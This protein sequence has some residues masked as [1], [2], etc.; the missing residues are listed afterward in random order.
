VRPRMGVA[1]QRRAE[2]DVIGDVG[3]CGKGASNSG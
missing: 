2:I 3:N 1:A